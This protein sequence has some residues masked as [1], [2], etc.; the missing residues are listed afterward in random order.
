MDYNLVSSLNSIK[1]L[2]GLTSE[3]LTNCL[4]ACKNPTSRRQSQRGVGEGSF[5]HWGHLP[6]VVFLIHTCN[7]I[8][9]SNIGLV[10]LIHV[11]N[12]F[13][14]V[15]IGL[16]LKRWCKAE[17][18]IE[19]YYQFLNF[20][21]PEIFRLVYIKVPKKGLKYLAVIFFNTYNY[22]LYICTIYYHSKNKND[23]R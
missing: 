14:V 22:I 23:G 15:N 9:V 4:R 5:Y 18:N 13:F 6:S 2:I 8:F 1:I 16:F 19:G 20:F 11:I 3:C 7:E 10:F 21:F 17:E 12:E